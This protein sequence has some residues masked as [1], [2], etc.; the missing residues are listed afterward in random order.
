MMKKLLHIG[1]RSIRSSFRIAGVLLAILIISVVSF[2]STFDVNQH[3]AEIIAAVNQAT[4]RQ[5]SIEGDLSLSV[6]LVPTIKAENVS[7]SNAT[8]GTAPNMVSA[9]QLE[10]QVALIPLING[11]VQI[12]KLW[13]SA[14]HIRL[15]VNQQGKGNWDLAPAAPPS[16]SDS[17]IISINQVNIEQAL[18]EMYD[19]RTKQTQ[20]FQ[21]EQLS[22]QAVDDNKLAV[23]LEASYQNTPFKLDGALGSP[24]LLLANQS[25]PIDV[26]I[27]TAIGDFKVLGIIKQPLTTLQPELELS[28]SVEDIT[29]LDRFA[30]AKL[31]NI[32]SVRFN[33]KFQLQDNIVT[34]DPF[35]LEAGNSDLAGAVTANISATIPIFTANL[36]ADRL[37]LTPFLPKAD[38]DAKAEQTDQLFSDAPLPMALL[39]GLEANVAVTAKQIH[40]DQQDFS[41]VDIKASLNQGHLKLDISKVGL[42]GGVLSGKFE[43]NDSVTPTKISSKL[44]LNGLDPSQIPSLS[45]NIS[46]ARSNINM[47][48]DTQGN[49]LHQLATQASGNMLVKVGEGK[50][51]MKK[52]HLFGGDLLSMLNPMKE[53]GGDTQLSCA[54]LNFKIK[55]GMAYTDKGIAVE[56]PQMT[57]IGSGNI[58]LNSEQLDIGLKTHAR[59]GLGVSVSNL[60]SFI[61]I[62]GTLANPQPTTDL[63]SAVGT[64]LKVQTA[65][66][67]GGLSLL[68]QGL[69]DRVT[70][71]KNPCETALK[72]PELKDD[73]QQK[74]GITDAIESLFD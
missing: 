17:T 48:I 57:V 11:Q 30:K 64:G 67:T 49:S 42:L 72:M 32:G 58:D 46:G 4:G 63:S 13:L 38:A 16:E 18:I 36:T 55:D 66:V 20:Q 71:D 23:S 41:N 3:K 33:A 50:V 65:I 31:P 43:I 51:D 21:I 26:T 73:K 5:L 59:E 44:A 39:H 10:L 35:Q 1:K 24:E 45:S 14:P 37:D 27:T 62:G 61:R 53:S 15:E 28:G 22:T 9:K 68:A 8:W 19:Q 69:F 47:E 12:E 56:T 7:F 60:A 70:A 6:R 40:T 29:A 74:S 2:I 52:A 34:V 54:V 25:F